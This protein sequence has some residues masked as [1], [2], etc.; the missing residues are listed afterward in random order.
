MEL[1]PVQA[2]QSGALS[3]VRRANSIAGVSF[4]AELSGHA[5]EQQDARKRHHS[6]DELPCEDAESFE[7][8]D[9]SDAEA[10]PTSPVNATHLHVIA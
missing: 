7:V 10:N 5:S 6:K 9:V 1:R 2:V 3:E 8:V 4:E